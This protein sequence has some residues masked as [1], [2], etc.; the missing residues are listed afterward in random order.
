MPASVVI[1][2]KDTVRMKP[3]YNIT[4]K[5]TKCFQSIV[6]SYGIACYREINPALYTI[7]TFPFLF[8]IMFGDIGHGIL[9]FLAALV[10]CIKEKKLAHVN[11]EVNYILIYINIIILQYFINS[12]FFILLSIY[13]IINSIHFYVYLLYVN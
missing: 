8:A 3:T 7:I 2:E 13:I 1:N 5:F 10:I 11:N 4:N 9:M 12:I 6:D